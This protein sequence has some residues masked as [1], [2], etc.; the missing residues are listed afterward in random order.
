MQQI[1]LLEREIRERNANKKSPVSTDR[2]FKA[3]FANIIY[4]RVHKHFIHG[5]PMARNGERDE[6]VIDFSESSF[7]HLPFIVERLAPIDF[8]RSVIGFIN[9]QLIENSPNDHNVIGVSSGG[10]IV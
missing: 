9:C 1:E 5:L 8:P 3:R 6:L 7:L 2:E 4:Q 10:I